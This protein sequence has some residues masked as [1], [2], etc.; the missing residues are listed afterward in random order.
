MLLLLL[1]L[2]LLH[3]DLARLSR[4]NVRVS[5]LAWLTGMGVSVSVGV[6]MSGLAWLARMG[7]GVGGTTG[8]TSVDVCV[9][10]RGKVT[11]AVLGLGPTVIGRHVIKR[12]ERVGHGGLR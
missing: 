9:S 2:L 5:G 6:G 7:M 10:T 4:M 1:L 3:R 12:V 11:T 8:L